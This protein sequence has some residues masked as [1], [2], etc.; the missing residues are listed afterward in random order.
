MKNYKV[1]ITRNFTDKEENISREIGTETEIFMCSK[2]RYEF[3]E[4]KG[5]VILLQVIEEK[6]VVEKVFE[7]VMDEIV[8]KPKKKTTKKKSKIDKE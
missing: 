6:P 4:S 3:L 1:Q 2:E 7:E 8:E 5:A